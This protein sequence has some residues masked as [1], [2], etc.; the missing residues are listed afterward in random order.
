MTT[1]TKRRRSSGQKQRFIGK[2]SGQV[3]QRVQ[4]VGPE[5]FGV[6]AVDCAKR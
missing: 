1:A 6:I 2:P 4:A 3:Q 5:H